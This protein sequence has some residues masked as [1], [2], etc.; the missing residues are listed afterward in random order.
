MSFLRCAPG[1]KFRLRRAR[2]IKI[3]SAALFHVAVVGVM[4]PFTLG[5]S[6]RHR[7]RERIQLMSN[8]PN[9]RRAHKVMALD[10]CWQFIEEAHVARVATVWADGSP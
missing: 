3:G 10:D 4:S 7:A 6:F 2:P 1:A 9:V 5:I 8:G